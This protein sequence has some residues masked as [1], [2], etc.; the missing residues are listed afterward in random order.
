MRLDS[1]TC[2]GRFLLELAADPMP[3]AE[4]SPRHG[5]KEW[6]VEASLSCA[7]ELFQSFSFVEVV[8]MRR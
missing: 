3:A 2:A 8:R 1:R 6:R 4:A 7:V 5:R